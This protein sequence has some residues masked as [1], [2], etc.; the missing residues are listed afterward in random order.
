[1]S[2]SLPGKAHEGDGAEAAARRPA[3]RVAAMVLL[4][5]LGLSLVQ[6]RAVEPE[7]FYSGDG[8]LKFLLAEQFARGDWRP[9]LRLAA[10][11]WAEALWNEEGLYP[12]GGPFVYREPGAEAR[13]WV[14]YPLVFPALS[15]FGVRAFGPR[16]LY[17]VP[18]L[19]LWLLWAVFLWLGR[20]L[21]LGPTALA[22]SLA[23]L[24]FASFSTVYGAIYWE[25]TLALLLGFAGFALLLGAS[26]PR[27]SSACGLGVAFA[28]G[29]LLGAA[30]WV[31]PESAA[32]AAAALAAAAIARVPWA[33]VL[34]SAAGSALPLLGLVAFNLWLHGDPL[35]V[36]ALQAVEPGTRHVPT[37][38]PAT[39]IAA[40]LG[41][42]F[43]VA[44]PV[45]AVACA[46]AL[47]GAAAR[48]DRGS[49]LEA[50][51]WA[52][53]AI[54]AL[55][56]IALVPNQGGKQEGAR[57]LMH[58]LPVLW[59][60]V[61]LQW[62]RATTRSDPSARVFRAAVLAALAAG[63]FLHAWQGT[64]DLARDYALRIRPALA[65]LRS[66]DSRFVA[67]EHQWIAQELASAFGEK[68]FFRV[69]NDASLDR[70][71]RALAERGVPHF[72]LIGYEPHE[73]GLRRGEGYA[74]RVLPRGHFGTLRI[75]DCVVKPMPN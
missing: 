32:F 3:T 39:R 68:L 60:I 73:E 7:L 37:T 15:A 71:A 14:Q 62:Q 41:R 52:A 33:P 63:V 70:L 18:A 56:A 67:V 20:A 30:V 28:A 46:W 61:G 57:Y 21:R 1:M 5:G 53:L 50:A 27:S 72:T 9:D 13:R 64:R 24:V 48:E 75:A 38:L 69:R 25:H 65:S 23:G 49:R 54:F 43:L 10:P 74:L 58:A 47:R 31:R 45:L 8:G 19:S 59:L 40:G 34:A 12:F 36:H 11:P 26:Q 42:H 35:G 29:L 55:V 22:L 44:T 2:A 17:V 16:G 6:L 4:L 51:L 66:V